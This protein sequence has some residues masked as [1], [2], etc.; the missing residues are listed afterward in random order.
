M[1][2]PKLLRPLAVILAAL[3]VITT[4]WRLRIS[5]LEPLVPDD[6][7]HG[8][9]EEPSGNEETDWSR[10]AYVQYVT[11]DNYLCNS[12]MLF[13]RL[14]SMH[15]KADRLLMYPD[16]ISTAEDDTSLESKLVRKARDEYN[17]K[18]QPIQV[19]SRPSGDGMYLPLRPF[20]GHMN[21]NSRE[22]RPGLRATPSS[23]LSTKLSMIEF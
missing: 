11:D 15:S 13:E 7:L 14:H 5:V 9:A 12:V 21:A 23:S 17:V 10:F 19:Q 6:L 16:N 8:H 18:L 1:A 4:L 22:K 20:S 2:S 3:L